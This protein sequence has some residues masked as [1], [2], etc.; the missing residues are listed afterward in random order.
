MMAL[1]SISRITAP[2]ENLGG[3]DDK[4]QDVRKSMDGGQ[5]VYSATLTESGARA[6]GGFGMPRGRRSGGMG[7]GDD[8]PETKG[9]IRV[10]VGKDGTI[11]T[12]VV[13]TETKMSFGERTMDMK[14]TTTYT[15][16]DVGATK[17]DVPD[18]ARKM[19]EEPDDAGG[20]EREG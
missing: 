18:E 13:H 11:E 9:T 1:M 10:T 3:I 2:H 5:V 8:A 20:E 14:R 15:V 16:S 12:I 4:V 6:F 7:G 17:V 19:L